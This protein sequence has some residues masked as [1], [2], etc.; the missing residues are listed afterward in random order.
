MISMISKTEGDA[1]CIEIYQLYFHA[2]RLDVPVQI[3]TRNEKDQYFISWKSNNSGRSMD[4]QML[5][6]LF[7]RYLFFIRLFELGFLLYGN[8]N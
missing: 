4:H 5:E 7:K 8:N 3:L 6:K 1:A 2:R